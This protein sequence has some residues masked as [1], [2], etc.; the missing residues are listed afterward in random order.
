MTRVLCVDF[1]STFTKA[2]LI[3]T[4]D[5]GLVA[6]ATHRTTSD[7]DVL[8]GYAATR[9]TPGADRAAA[10]RASTSAGAGGGRAGGLRGAP[11]SPWRRTCRGGSGLQQRRGRAAARGG[12]VRA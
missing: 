9:R 6:T 5:G 11:A 2:A 7:T 12:R 8:E 1:G 3:D 4:D 10:V